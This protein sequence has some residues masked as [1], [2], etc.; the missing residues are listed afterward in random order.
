MTDL[1][2]RDLE[3]VASPDQVW[4][5][6]T[7]PAWLEAWLAD[8]VWLELWPGGDARF[9]IGDQERG[10]WVEEVVPPPA[11]PGTGDCGRLAFW[12]AVD[13]EPASRVELELIATDH[14]T[15]LRVIETRPLEVLDLVGVPL[16]GQGGSRFGPAL[17]AA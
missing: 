6:L 1:M 2:Q 11:D 14:G 15:R 9:V 4:Q 5:A 10:G 3:L 16:P 17:V 8:E 12:W 13:D 7:D